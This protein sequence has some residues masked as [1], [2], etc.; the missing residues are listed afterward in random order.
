MELVDGVTLRQRLAEPPVDTKEAL[1]LATAI[2]DGL[3]RAH[4]AGI[5]HRD[6]KPRT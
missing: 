4:A 2:A 5:V 6:L 1:R 3:T